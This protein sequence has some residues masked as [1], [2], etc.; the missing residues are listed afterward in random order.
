MRLSPERRRVGYLPQDYGL[1]P[2]MTV[3]ANV[4]FAPRR[5]RPDLLE[6][7]R[8]THLADAHPAQLSGGERQRVALA[9]ALARDPVVL[10]LD[11]P[12]GALDTI[13]RAHVRD[14]L[15]ETLADITLPTLLVTHAFEDA[16]ALAD[17]I[18][19]IDNG[20]LVQL[21]A[22]TEVLTNPADATVAALT[23]ANVLRGV[24]TSTPTRS[25][26]LLDGGGELDTDTHANGVVDIAVHPWA[27]ELTAPDASRL[28]DRI[29][30][31]R[32]DRGT[33]VINLTR[34][35]VHTPASPNGPP[36]ITENTI[37]G[38][39]AAPRDVRVLPSNRP[40]GLTDTTG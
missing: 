8:I 34:L 20:N 23:G 15:T 33:L 32:R 12:F 3:A 4:S 6:R 19:V 1:F 35:T 37:V 29:V 24:A 40:A 13:T 25:I 22:P 21:A 36:P 27:L 5:D 30:S 14:E 38:L 28:T 10:L 18:G 16:T 2:H 11:E 39:R 17:R 7:L 9:R 31:L 26:V